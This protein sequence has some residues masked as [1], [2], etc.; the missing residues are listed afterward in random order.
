M[1]ITPIGYSPLP[2]D[3]ARKRPSG[4][5]A[6]PFSE[7]LVHAVREVDSLQARAGDLA[8]A[9]A[10]GHDVDVHDAVLAAEEADLAFQFTLQVRNKLIEAYQEVMRMQI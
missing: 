10:M 6:E 5:P 3:L 8:A 1:E 4:Q 9:L 2:L 7:T